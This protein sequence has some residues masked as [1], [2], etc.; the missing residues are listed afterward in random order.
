[1][2]LSTGPASGATMMGGHDMP[3]SQPRR[4]MQQCMDCPASIVGP[5]AM[6][7]S[8]AIPDAANQHCS[9]MQPPNAAPVVADSHRFGHIQE[10]LP[11]LAL[12]FSTSA[13][14]RYACS[15]STGEA[16]THKEDVSTPTWKVAMNHEYNV[17]MENKTWPLVPP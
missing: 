2:A 15:S 1:M 11:L 10:S 7:S 12:G 4:A 6:Q 14:V 5:S 3:C 9:V 16:T 17:L 8:N 13:T